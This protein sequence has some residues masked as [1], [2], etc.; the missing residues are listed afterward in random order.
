MLT[1]CKSTQPTREE[2]TDNARSLAEQL[3]AV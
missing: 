1:E 2:V 3:R